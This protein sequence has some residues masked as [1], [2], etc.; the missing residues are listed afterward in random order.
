[1]PSARKYLEMHPS[2]AFGPRSKFKKWVDHF[3]YNKFFGLEY[4]ASVPKY[5]MSGVQ[6]KWN[7]KSGRWSDEANR[8]FKQF[9]PKFE[10][11]I[12]AM[13]NSLTLADRQFGG[14]TKTVL[15]AIEARLDRVEKA[16]ENK[17]QSR[18]I[19]GEQAFASGG[20]TNRIT[21]EELKILRDLEGHKN[22]ILGSME[23]IQF[24]VARA[25]TAYPDSK[26]EIKHLADAREIEGKFR[27]ITSNFMQELQKNNS[28][29]Q[30][31]FLENS[32]MNPQQDSRQSRGLRLRPA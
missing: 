27:G 11:G 22:E 14:N 5:I 32:L 12:E 17:V 26:Q 7:K 19:D 10:G 2:Y 15:D 29:Y 18:E 21:R 6:W 25:A 28:L 9:Y 13:R 8:R 24:S 30:K 16:H 31:L 4:V 3:I 20:L 1:M 23:R